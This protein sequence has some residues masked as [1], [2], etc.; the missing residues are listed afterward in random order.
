[1]EDTK[2]PFILRFL[3]WVKSLAILGLAALSV[4]LTIQLWL[5]NI[6]NQ[7]FFPYVEARFTTAAPDG[8]SAF[9]RPFRIISGVG[10][11]YFDIMYSYIEYSD[12]WEN[13]KSAITAILQ[14][15]TFIGRTETDISDMLA[16]PVLIYEYAFNMTPLAFTQAFGQRSGIFADAEMPY[17]RAIAIAPHQNR[18]EPL[19][20]F[21]INNDYTW[22]FSLAST[23]TVSHL[24]DGI[25]ILPPS[26]PY[27]RFVQTENPLVFLPHF[28]ENFSYH[29]L[30]VTNPYENHSGVLQMAF[31]HRQVEHFFAN[32][33]T[34][35]HEVVNGIYTF[36]N[37]NTVVR[38]LPGDVVEYTSFSTIGRTS[39]GF[40]EDFSAAIA[41]IES[42]PNISNA[43]FL[44]GYDMRG[45][46]NVFWF[47]Y[48]VNDFPLMLAAYW[49]TNP[50]CTNPLRY[51]IEV[52]VDNGRIVRYRKIPFT[53]EIDMS[54]NASLY[55][56]S[57]LDAE[58][59]SIGFV[60]APGL[61][62]QQHVHLQVQ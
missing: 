6:P 30:I 2:R 1:M 45:R 10:D 31:I 15:G 42:D 21:F 53:F 49:Y 13:G 43:F 12:F 16:M 35:N 7:S 20:I 40:I 29:P 24:F 50:D 22:Q 11:G 33:A 26:N 5:V 58:A 37:L 34:M 36:R 47:N 14:S 9:V 57:S 18:D 59:R 54:V 25:E 51:Q 3:P 8:A 38:Y 46:E 32:P 60:I 41:F 27:R 56:T 61:R 39:S 62:S 23:R 44:A 19:S 52:S 17:F 4:F 28:H 48:V 55:L